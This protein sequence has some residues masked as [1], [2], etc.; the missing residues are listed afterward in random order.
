MEEN[1]ECPFAS[2][3]ALEIVVVRLTP[4]V[5]S[6]QTPGCTGRELGSGA[7][8]RQAESLPQSV[9]RSW[10]V[11]FTSPSQQPRGGDGGGPSSCRVS[12]SLA[13]F[14]VQRHKC[15]S[16]LEFE[17]KSASSGCKSKWQP[18]SGGMPS[19]LIPQNGFI[20]SSVRVHR[21]SIL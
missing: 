21:C 7:C 3:R 6:T 14:W 8:S 4:A 11:C 17:A 10:L 20:F 13:C 5:L 2:E 18:G 19:Y 1:E 15:W 12:E 16:L 9:S